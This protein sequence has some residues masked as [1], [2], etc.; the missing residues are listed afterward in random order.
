MVKKIIPILD[1]HPEGILILGENNQVLYHNAAM[2]NL[3]VTSEIDLAFLFDQQ[4]KKKFDEF[5]T[6]HEEKNSNLTCEL[7]VLSNKGK[8]K[9]VEVSL[10][11]TT[12]ENKNVILLIMKDISIQNQLSN[13]ILRAELAEETNKILSSEIEKRIKTEHLLEE[14]YIRTRSIF[15][16]SYN[17]FLLTLDKDYNV[18]TINSHCKNYFFELTKSELQLGVD[19]FDF[20]KPY[21]KEY[22]LKYFEKV[23]KSVLQGNSEQLEID[24]IIENNVKWMEIFL[25]PI[26][27]IKNHVYEISL[28]AHDI[29]DKKLNERKIIA[30]LEEKEVLLK[31]IHHRVKNNL[32]VI[33]SILNLQSMY[34]KDKN[35]LE[36]LDESR[37]RIRSMA[38]IHEH[39]YQTKNFSSILFTDYIRNIVSNLIASY[40]IDDKKIDFIDELEIVQLNIDQAIPCGLI[41]NE[42]VSNSL[43]YAFPAKKGGTILVALKEIGNSIELRI[44]DNGRGFPEN[45]NIF[46]TN[47]LGLQLV[48]T[49]VEQLEG[50]INYESYHGIKYLITFDK[51]G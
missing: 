15:E 44:E 14:Q 13:E 32:Q 5:L 26:F 35:T 3:S 21:F 17:T 4:N 31:E 38:I 51:I 24:F 11:K 22:E 42:L 43:K 27:S 45:F 2:A 29:T 41:L 36:I 34:V 19:F 7:N 20:F 46:K 49:L 50:Q 12:F 10:V 39:L 16:S 28:V 23:L 25:N 8:I 47:T 48:S 33:S 37:N 18:T 30:S 1:N 9:N 6:C 40:N